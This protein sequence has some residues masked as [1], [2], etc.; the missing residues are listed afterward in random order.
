MLVSQDCLTIFEWTEHKHGS[1]IQKNFTTLCALLLTYIVLIRILQK[2]LYLPSSLDNGL[3]RK[4][5]NTL[6]HPFF[7]LAAQLDLD[8]IWQ[9]DA[10]AVIYRREAVAK[11][12][13]NLMGHYNV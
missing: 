2:S 7:Q 13:S 9:R 12:I 8:K 4:L 1:F 3:E 11:P 5:P 10:Q 6:S